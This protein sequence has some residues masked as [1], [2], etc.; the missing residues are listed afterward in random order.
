[1]ATPESAGYPEW[2]ATACEHGP[3]LLAL[4]KVRATQ[5]IRDDPDA[6]WVFDFEAAWEHGPCSHGERILIALGWCLYN[7]SWAAT[8]DAEHGGHGPLFVSNPSEAAGTLSAGWWATYREMIDL[9]RR[10]QH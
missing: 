3:A 6:G 5:Y 8:Y 2:W 10:G 1:M 4:T 7:L 9:A